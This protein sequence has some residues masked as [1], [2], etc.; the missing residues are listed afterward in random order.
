L[1]DGNNNWAVTIEMIGGN[2]HEIGEKNRN[3]A[4]KIRRPKYGMKTSQN[5]TQFQ[6]VFCRI[7]MPWEVMTS[8]NKIRHEIRHQKFLTE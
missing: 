2:E 6:E 7:L 3:T 1:T 5:S 4:A 8:Q